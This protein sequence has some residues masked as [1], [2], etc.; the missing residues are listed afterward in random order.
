MRTLEY[1]HIGKVTCLEL[2]VGDEFQRTVPVRDDGADGRVEDSQRTG[3]PLEQSQAGVGVVEQPVGISGDAHAGIDQKVALLL[4]PSF[5]PVQHPAYILRPR[6]CRVNTQRDTTHMPAYGFVK[7]VAGAQPDGAQQ[8]AM[9]FFYSHQLLQQVVDA[10][11]AAGSQQQAVACRGQL[12]AT[13]VCLTSFKHINC[14]CLR[15][16]LPADGA[17]DGAPAPHCATVT[18]AGVEDDGNLVCGGIFL[19]EYLYGCRSEAWPYR[20]RTSSVMDWFCEKS[21]LPIR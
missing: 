19:H 11:V 9:V 5:I 12:C 16:Q 18:G 2:G 1:G 14:C 15:Q 10:A 21:W 7:I 3:A 8:R 4:L 20:H 17:F 6:Q 13:T